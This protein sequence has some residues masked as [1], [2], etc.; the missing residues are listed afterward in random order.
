MADGDLHAKETKPLNPNLED[1]QQGRKAAQSTNL[2]ATGH[3]LK[4]SREHQ[5][6]GQRRCG[7][8]RSQENEV[9]GN[10]VGTL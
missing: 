3:I 9:R 8:C 4:A 1:A 7:G 10:A 6:I 5:D 2:S